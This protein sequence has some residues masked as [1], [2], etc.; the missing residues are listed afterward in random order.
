MHQIH[1]QLYL[2]S[3]MQGVNHIKSLIMFQGSLITQNTLSRTRFIKAC[4]TK[5]IH[6]CQRDVL[7]AMKRIIILVL[8]FAEGWTALWCW[9]QH[10]TTWIA[11]HQ[12][13]VQLRY[14][15]HRWQTC[16]K[17]LH[18]S[19]R[20]EQF[21]KATPTEGQRNETLDVAPE[22]WEG[23]FKGRMD[24]GPTLLQSLKW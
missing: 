8:K 11:V 20:R 13:S 4:R 16:L 1:T 3:R 15:F 17:R 22:I 9:H 23:M 18:S 12:W 5:K 24:E 10:F 21:R 6:S 14:F 7:C 19:I 2:I